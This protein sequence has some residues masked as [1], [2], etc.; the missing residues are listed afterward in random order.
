MQIVGTCR[1]SSNLTTHHI[2]L[3]LNYLPHMES[4]ESLIF[5]CIKFNVAL[6]VVQPT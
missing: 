3:Y 4:Q 1:S 6:P 2:A 5:T